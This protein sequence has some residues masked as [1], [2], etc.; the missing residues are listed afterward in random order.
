VRELPLQPAAFPRVLRFDVFEVDLRARELRK[1]GRSTGLPEQSV[2]ILVMLLDHPGE[3]VLREEIRKKL[4]PNDTAVEFD[5]GINAAIQ[6]LRQALGD[7]ADNPHFIETL[8]RRGYRWIAPI[9]SSEP[10]PPTGPD[11]VV[12]PPHAVEQENSNLI[13]KKVSHYR[14]LEM[15]GGGGMGLVYKAEDLKL[16]RRVAL[17]FLPE[18]VATDSLTLRRF[19]REARTASSLS[20]PNICTIYEVEEH[21]GHPFIVMELL[22]GGTLRELIAK[23]AISA[24]DEKVQLPLERL[25]DIG[26]QVAYGLDA[27][28][29]KGIIHRDIKPANIFI[30]TEGHIKILDFG[31]AKLATASTEIAAEELVEDHSNRPPARTTSRTAIEDS[32]TRTGM[33]MGTAGYMSP[34]QVRGEHLDART[35]LFSFGLVMYEMATGQRAFSGET[36]PILHDAILNFTPVPA[37]DLNAKIPPKLEEI[38]NKALEKN[39][40]ARYQ[41]ASEISADLNRLRQ[42][43]ATRHR[44]WTIAVAGGFLA[45]A[46]AGMFWF[47]KRQPT[48]LPELKLRQ[49]TTNSSENPVRTGAIS[50]DGKYLAYADRSGIRLKLIETGDS[51]AIPQPEALKDGPVDWQIVQWFPNGTRFLANIAPPP[52]RSSLGQ[53]SSVWTVSMLGGVPRKLRDNAYASPSSISPDG[54]LIAFGTNQ[55]KY[56]DREIWV[57]GPTGEQARKIYESDEN[58]S[59]Q[60]PQWTSDGRRLGY[61]KID[62]SETSIETRDLQGGP[63]VRVLSNIGDSLMDYFWLPDGRMFYVLIERGPNEYTCNFWQVRIDKDTGKVVEEPR[64]LTNWTGFCIDGGSITADGKRISFGEWAGQLSVYVAELGANGTRLSNAR[65]LS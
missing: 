20:H 21:E 19:E 10:N 56:G 46:M 3:V 15:V 44:R 24:G 29:R 34:E 32:L 40:G 25:L 42:Q 62:K 45:A 60:G 36:A 41:H 53:H 16:G 23:A 65:R 11:A 6:R 18:E 61:L 58:S 1:N 54:S 43:A 63:S 35:D 28:H 22:E 7:S 38:I 27:A 14:V 8:P 49:V 37:H 9:E 5:H 13:G 51:Q 2:K 30:T 64:R 55:G 48:S 31:L 4:W 50:P 17:K 52:E 59:I 12:G 47:I 57:M 39:P 26:L 33:A